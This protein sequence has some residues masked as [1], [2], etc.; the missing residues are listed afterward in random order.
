[1]LFAAAAHNL[2]KL[3]KQYVKQPQS[4]ALVI[5]ADHLRATSGLLWRAC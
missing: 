5:Q 4:I 3:L 2:N 1:M